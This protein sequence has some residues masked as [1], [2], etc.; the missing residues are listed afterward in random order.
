MSTLADGE[1]VPRKGGHWIALRAHQEVAV[2]EQSIV[3]SC[4]AHDP[5]NNIGRAFSPVAACNGHAWR[6]A[7]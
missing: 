3:E 5:Y 4:I 7:V 6:V 2:C 1:C